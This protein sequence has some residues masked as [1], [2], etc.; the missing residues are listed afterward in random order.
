MLVDT[1]TCSLF[2]NTL[3]I[4]YARLIYICLQVTDFG[5][6]RVIGARKAASELKTT[7][8]GTVTHQ[9]PE[10]LRDGASLSLSSICMR[11]LV[12]VVMVMRM[13]ALTFAFED[14]IHLHTAGDF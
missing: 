2:S 3:T 4:P 12:Q 8:Y 7:S 11:C 10:L 5:F 13:F 9:P 1:F 6:S 14:H